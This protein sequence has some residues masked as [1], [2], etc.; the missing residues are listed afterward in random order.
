MGPRPGREIVVRKFTDA[1]Y[2]RRLEGAISFG[3]PVMIENVGEELD[4]AIEPVL[5]RQTFKKGP[6]L[7]GC[8]VFIYFAVLYNL[9]FFFS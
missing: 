2:I 6:T 7:R 4:P 1:D 3:N 8:G 5:L 9:L